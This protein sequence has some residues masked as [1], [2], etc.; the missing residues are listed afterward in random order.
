MTAL[1]FAKFT[2]RRPLPL[3]IDMTWL[4][5]LSH[6]ISAAN[7][8]ISFGPHPPS[9]ARNGLSEVVNAPIG[10][11]DAPIQWGFITGFVL[12]TYLHYLARHL[13]WMRK[14]QETIS[15]CALQVQYSLRLIGSLVMAILLVPLFALIMYCFAVYRKCLELS[16]RQ[17]YKSR[18]RGLL[19]GHDANWV[20]EDDKCKSVINVLG[21]FDGVE[22]SAQILMALRKRLATRLLGKHQPHPK[23]FYRRGITGGFAFWYKVK[24]SEIHIEDFVRLCDIPSESDEFVTVEELKAWIGEMYNAD[25]PKGHTTSWEILVSKKPLKEASGEHV[26]VN[27]VK[28]TRI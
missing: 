26:L 28:E 24:D 25:L 5:N 12:S 7:L 2:R 22:S 27:P 13:K 19:E 20:L 9:E 15:S 8:S 11:W 21:T 18:F 10:S 6:T 3:D 23:L 16:L 4:Q 1:S 17:K 14:V